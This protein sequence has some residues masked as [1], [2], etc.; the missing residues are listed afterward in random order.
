MSEPGW[1]PD[2]MGKAGS[3]R[4]FDGQQWTTSVS[5]QA[6]QP[7]TGQNAPAGHRPPPASGGQ[8][9]QD[10]PYGPSGQQPPGHGPGSGTPAGQPREVLGVQLRWLLL[11]AGIIIL[12]A[13]L[14]GSLVARP[15]NAPG[16]GEDPATTDGPGTQTTDDPTG[17]GGRDPDKYDCRIGNGSGS[18]AR[19]PKLGT[20]GLEMTVPADWPWRYSLD[21]WTWLDDSASWGRVDVGP[22]DEGW[23]TGVSIGRIGTDGEGPRS[24]AEGLAWAHECLRR[25]DGAFGD[26]EYEVQEIAA[27]DTR[28]GDYP[29]KRVAYAYLLP[30]QGKLSYA[31]YEVTIMIVEM[32]DDGLVQ[33]VGWAPG[34]SDEMETIAT[35][36]Q[37]LQAP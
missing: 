24:A 33:V 25:P 9:P 4:Y 34:G 15:S 13:V 6:G 29:A 3:L 31:G 16:P 5:D 22:G 18:G 11:A 12:A 2:P 8:Y 1:Y 10:G 17:P 30:D 32:P 28:V 37:S 7:P 26:L 19:P 36:L 20:P 14:I 27:G 35:A 23:A 21:Y